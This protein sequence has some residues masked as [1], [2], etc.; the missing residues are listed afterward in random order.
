MKPSLS[1]LASLLL[2]APA[3][4][5]AAVPPPPADDGRVVRVIDGN[6]VGVTPCGDPF[7]VRLSCSRAPALVRG[8]AGEAAQ[9][10]LPQLLPPGTRVTLA[11]RQ[12]AVDGV[13]Q[14]EILAAGTS[15]PVNLTLFEQGL[16]L[17]DHRPRSLCDRQRCSQ[18]ER[19]ARRRR[20]G[21]WGSVPAAP[22][23]RP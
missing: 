10:A 6:T 5:A 14:A 17:W 16:A 23:M 15:Q 11:S 19:A 20:L 7:N 9:V 22:G 12:R 2:L 18:A 13:E 3:L 8:P 21:L 1:C 4:P